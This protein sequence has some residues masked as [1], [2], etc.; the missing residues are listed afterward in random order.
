[1]IRGVFIGKIRVKKQVQNLNFE[2]KGLLKSVPDEYWGDKESKGLFPM[3]AGLLS[4]SGYANIP[5]GTF[6]PSTVLIGTAV[7][8]M[9]CQKKKRKGFL[10]IMIVTCLVPGGIYVPSLVTI[11]TSVRDLHCQEMAKCNPDVLVGTVNVPREPKMPLFFQ[12]L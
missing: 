8:E 3:L 5:I 6:V 4:R 12:K 7:R 11:V 2:R 10:G 9:Y 1:M